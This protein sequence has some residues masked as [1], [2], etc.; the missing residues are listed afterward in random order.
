MNYQQKIWKGTGVIIKS[1]FPLFLYIVIPGCLSVIGKFLRRFD[2]NTEAFLLESGNFY[3]MLGTVICF[4]ILRK[5]A[6]KRGNTLIKETTLDTENFD[7]KLALLYLGLGFFSALSISALI[8]VLPLPAFLKQSYTESASSIFQ[9]TDLVLAVFN[10]LILAP[11][12]EEMIFRGYMLN[13][14]LSFFG[15]KAAVIISSGVFA[16]CHVNLIWMIYAFAI[17]LILG[18]TAI[19]KDNILY[20]IV[21]HGGFNL[22]SA[23]NLVL[24]HT[25]LSEKLFFASRISVVLFGIVGIL[26]VILIRREL[27]GREEWYL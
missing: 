26:S 11:V 17:G 27:E 5:S 1:L 14:L 25:G 15:E 22:F 19:K 12:V 24:L 21:L 23:V 8:T 16:A 9:R 3:Q 13:S 18:R 7:R 20:G 2:G 4:L 6:K 10:L